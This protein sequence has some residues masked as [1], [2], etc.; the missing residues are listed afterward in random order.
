MNP[1][2]IRA[3]ITSEDPETLKRAI[4]F[5][6][7]RI[8]L[9]GE[10]AKLAETRATAM[11]AVSG[12]LAG[13]VVNFGK[14]IHNL[15]VLDFL[16][17]SALYFSSI[18]LFIKAV[19][20]AVRVLWVLK[21]YELTPDLAFDLQGKSGIDALREELT[22][23]IWEYWATLPVTNEKLFW[24][25]RSQR[26]TVSAIIVFMFLGAPYSLKPNLV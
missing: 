26:N 18:F 15:N 20:Y 4:S 7:N 13:F 5:V 8:A 2:N 14:T 25:N 6:E 11:L 22:W 19:F 21:G 17:F 12:V 10:R 9:M 23:R 3:K 24:L 16:L 1:E